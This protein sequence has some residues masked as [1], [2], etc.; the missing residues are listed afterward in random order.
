MFVVCMQSFD[1]GKL[2]PQARIVAQALKKYGMMVAD[3]G[4]PWYITG[5]PNS[6]WDN[7]DLHTLDEIKGS[8]YEVVDMA[9]VK[10]Y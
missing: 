9:S 10:K 6:K 3:N 1:V 4:G 8:D 7:D 2:K 5:V